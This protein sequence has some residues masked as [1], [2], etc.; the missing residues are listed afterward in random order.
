GIP[1]FFTPAGV[2]TQ[3]ADGKEMREFNGREYILEKALTADFSFVRAHRGDKIGNLI[4][5]KTAQNFNPIIAT[6]GKVTVAE[7]AEVVENGEF[8]PNFVH[9]PSIYTQRVIQGNQ[10]K[11]IDKR[12]VDLSSS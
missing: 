8:N 12:T 7:V 6:A 9:T 5:N 10:E 4:Y 2:G 11:R 1:A 3:I